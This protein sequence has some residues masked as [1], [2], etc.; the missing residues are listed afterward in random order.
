MAETGTDSMRGAVTGGVRLLLLLEGFALFAAMVLLYFYRGGSWWLFAALFLAPDLSFAAYLA[1]PRIGA[2][3]YNAVHTT[4]AP[5]LLLFAG[6][7]VLDD[8]LTLSIAV[9]WLAHIGIDRA[10]GYGLKYS[11]GFGLTHLGRIGKAA[12][13]GGAAV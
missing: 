5:T 7:L 8:K 2:A 13:G 9:I 4:I 6:F 12:S 11:G 10:V 3:V 1:G